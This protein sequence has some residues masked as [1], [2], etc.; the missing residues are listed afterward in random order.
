[1]ATTIIKR[2]F[3]HPTAETAIAA[4]PAKGEFLDLAT[5]QAA[6]WFAL[7]SIQEGE[8]GDIDSEAVK[9]KPLAEGVA[10]KAPGAQAMQDYI[11]R[12]GGIE[13]VEFTAY[14]V[15]EGVYALAS[16]VAEDTPGSGIYDHTKEQTYRALLVETETGLYIDWYPRVMLAI[17]SED[18]GFGPGDDAVGKFTFTARVL[19]SAAV[20]CK[21]GRM[22]VYLQPAT[23]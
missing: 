8:D 19:D 21:G 23:S 22:R 18:A 7:G 16:N 13:T 10:I 6:G 15:D 1:M 11:G 5:M 4:A 9:I 3:I 12:S 14:D 2:I 17:T 20:G